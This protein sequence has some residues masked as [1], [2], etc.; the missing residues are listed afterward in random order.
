ML[1]SCKLNVFDLAQGSVI[2]VRQH[3]TNSP[4]LQKENQAVAVRVTLRNFVLR[5]PRLEFRAADRLQSLT[6]SECTDIT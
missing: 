4:V 2:G 3:A 6:V 5:C 1:R